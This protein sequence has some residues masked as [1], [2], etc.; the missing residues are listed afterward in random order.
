MAYNNDEVFWS[1]LPMFNYKDY[2][3]NTNSIIDL[4]VSS[5]TTDFKT[6][7]P[8]NLNLT[9]FTSNDN[10][11]RLQLISYSNVFDLLDSAVYASKNIDKIYEENKFEI[12][13][14]YSQD[15]NLIFKF[16]KESNMGERCVVIEIIHNESDF[17]KI[18]ID[19][20]TY[21]SLITCIKQYQDNYIKILIDLKS[22]FLMSEIL[23][24]SKLTEKGV[25]TLI[26][27]I[28]NL[29]ILPEVEVI[30]NIQNENQ[31]VE[32]N[33]ELGFDDQLNELDRFIENSNIIIPE[34]EKINK[35]LDNPIKKIQNNISSLLVEKVLKFDI[36]K[37]EDIINSTYLSPD[38]INEIIKLFKEGINLPFDFDF[39]PGIIENDRKSI[40]YFSKVLFSTIFQT[41]IKGGSIPQ[42]L[43]SIKYRVDFNKS[44]ELNNEIAYDLLIINSYLKLFRNKVS[45]KEE[46]SSINKS[47]MYCG[48]RCFTDVLTFSFLENKNK[49][50][51]K[52]TLLTR[53]NFFK[54]KGFFKNYDMILERYNC[55]LIQENEMSKAFEEVCEKVIGSIEF[56]DVIHKHFYTKGQL[57]LP[58]ENK[59]SKE[60]IIN[61]FIR[62]ELGV[63]FKEID[64]EKVVDINKDI[65]DYLMGFQPKVM[66]PSKNESMIYKYVKSVSEEIPER[67]RDNLLSYL[68]ELKDNY[69]F[70]NPDFQNDE[71]GENVLKALYE[72]N[73]S[74]KKMTNSNFYL[75]IE[76][77]LMTKEL[78]LTKIRGIK[79][80]KIDE[81]IKDQSDEAWDALML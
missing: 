11:R 4:K 36:S 29:Q 71:L 21:R 63:K 13:K 38:P 65:K 47:I 6:F 19:F 68:M 74:D 60:Q 16:R 17:G 10:K 23:Q 27:S 41:H 39:L 28:T 31:L 50:S 58:Y 3:Y 46:S 61:D 15:R 7:T 56:V 1:N 80:G 52:K 59:L 5:S 77:S 30:K 75:R 48:A 51:L 64:I 79:E 18:I 44:Q 22:S 26:G 81:E 25:K 66:A 14:R 70:N 42:G 37:F 57:K 12:C 73:E 40:L 8:P 67:F 76:E 9:I 32:E 55:T 78:I 49:D 54:E 34:L 53:F 62:F 24:I 20:Q 45:D 2:K 69:D 43:P 33:I 72:W 35:E